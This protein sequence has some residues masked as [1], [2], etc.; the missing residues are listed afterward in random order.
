M[1]R[2]DREITSTGEIEAILGECKVCRLAMAAGDE[3]Y[4]VPLNYGY[5]LEG[6]E[7]TLY[8]H[9]AREGRKLGLLR[10]NPRVC[11]EIDREGSLLAGEN[12]C[13]YSFS[14]ASVIGTGTVEFLD[15]EEKERA[16]RII[17]ECQTGKK[18]SLAFGAEELA[19]VTAYRV[20]AAEFTGKKRV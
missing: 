12:A 8:F 6:G 7:L 5:T 15:G 2:K 4:I 10:R 20:K 3:I 17:V 18:G 16:L 19:M 14:F 9:S 13:S 1:R 11:F